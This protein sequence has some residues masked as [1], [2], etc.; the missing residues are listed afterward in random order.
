MG[1]KSHCANY[2]LLIVPQ[3]PCLCP[4]LR[5]CGW[6]WSMSC[7]VSQA[8]SAESSTAVSPSASSPVLILAFILFSP[9]GFLLYSALWNTEHS[10][11]LSL[12]IFF[13]LLFT[14]PLSFPSFPL[15]FP[16]STSLPFF[17][18]PS[19]LSYSFYVFSS[20]HFS[21]HLHFLF[22]QFIFFSNQ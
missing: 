6:I 2:P 14:S 1:R 5:I 22:P 18:L 16:F 21:P 12:H 20:F 13:L 7:S 4:A 15:D 9:L 8:A 19:H 11:S 10:L 17:N 3:S